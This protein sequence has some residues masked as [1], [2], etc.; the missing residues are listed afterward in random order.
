[1]LVYNVPRLRTVAIPVLFACTTL[2][3]FAGQAHAADIDPTGIGDL[4]PS[5]D[6]KVPEGEGTLYET[7]SNP[8]LWQLDSDFGKRDVL[9][10]MAEAIADI[11]MGLIAVL[12]T[13]C[14]VIVQWIFQLTTVPELENAIT[15]SIGGAAKGLTATLLPSALAVGGL[16]A[17]A[18]HK[19]GGGGGGLSQIAWVLISGVVAVS[20]LTSPQTWVGGIDSARQI[21]SSV[22]LNATSQGL[23]DGSEDFPFEL[24]HKPKFSGNGRDDALRK[25]SDAVWRAYVATPWCVAEFG[26]FEVCEKYGKALLDLGSD[27]DKRKEWLKKNVDTDAVG[28]D[29]VKW[30]Q[31]HSPVGR[32]MVTIPALISIILFAALILMLAFTSLASLL[33]ALMLLLTGVIFA[34]LW[35]IPGRPREW[36]LAW[37]DQ[38]LARTLESLIATMVLGAVLSLQAATTQ[39]FDAYGW[40]PTSGLSIAAA[41]VGM[42]FRA[43]V[44]QIFGVRG[45]TSGMLGG[46]ALA[47]ML[48]RGGGGGGTSRRDFDHKPVRTLPGR[49]RGRGGG[50][51]GGGDDL[52]QLPGGGGGGA[53]DDMDVVL[54]RAPRHRPPAPAPRPLPTAGAEA[55]PAL[56]PGSGAAT[57][58]GRSDGPVITL[59]RERPDVT[60]KARTTLPPQPSR[61]RPAL[62]SGK[63]TTAPSRPRPAL[64][65]GKEI[66]AGAGPAAAAGATRPPVG[67]GPTP[68]MRP[69]SGGAPNYAFRQ[70]PPPA[71]A[72]E[73][74]VIQAT[75]IRSTP[76]GPPPR[77]TGS[78]QP[79]P[80]ATA[81][82]RRTAAPAVP[83]PR[84]TARR[85]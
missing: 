30:R 81:P 15:K 78:T 4:M 26:S 61:P 74:K 68:V 38:L 34:C 53:A 75:V 41:I 6:N 5:T 48:T 37:F 50:G 32:I 25:S 63:E 45:T 8:S 46:L 11:C 56:P 12:G 84:N 10:P 40:L 16:V 55:G 71:R 76:N 35:V 62:P 44:A 29:S 13:A 43:V 47:K 2:M 80:R 49:G 54:T 73:P 83:A 22:T 82:A 31:G 33:G 69:E 21:G 7:Y 20:L 14:I 64:P 70:A 52:P 58:G 77:P 72:G 18:Q 85:G 39:M 42:N 57:S 79:P 1:M 51:G 60:G 17:F 59:D 66:T 28:A 36:G 23:G 24:G 65:S 27:K 3:V 19:K 67:P 9:D